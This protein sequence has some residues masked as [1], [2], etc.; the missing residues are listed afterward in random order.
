MTFSTGRVVPILSGFMANSFIESLLPQEGHAPV[1]AQLYVYDN[2]Q[3]AHEHHQQIVFKSSVQ[4]Q[5]FAN[6]E[7]NWNWNWS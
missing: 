1:Y 7:E 3:Q 2:A 4:F 5:S 6:F